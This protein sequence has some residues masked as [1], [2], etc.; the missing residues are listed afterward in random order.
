MVDGIFR[1]VVGDGVYFWGGGGWCWIHFGWWWVVVGIFWVV[2][3]RGGSWLMVVGGGTV[4]N[5]PC[6][7]LYVGTLISYYT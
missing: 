1:V 5:S 3:R 4:Y 6:N 7:K 2:V